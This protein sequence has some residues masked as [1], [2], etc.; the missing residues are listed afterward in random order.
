KFRDPTVVRVNSAGVVYVADHFNNRV[1]KFETPATGATGE[2]FG[3]GFIQ[4]SAIEFDDTEPGRIWIYN[5]G[6]S[7]LE[8]WDETT[9]TF[10]RKVGRDD[11]PNLLGAATGSIGFDSAGNIYAAVGEGETNNTVL[12]FDKADYISDPN[13]YSYLLLEPTPHG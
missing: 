10:I 13:T 12:I 2:E 11:D 5:E 6:R 3:S 1:L 7:R 9:E 4:P 8:L